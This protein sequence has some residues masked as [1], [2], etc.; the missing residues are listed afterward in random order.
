[1]I[2]LT[3]SLFGYVVALSI[4][5]GEVHAE[6]VLMYILLDPSF[7]WLHVWDLWTVG[8]IFGGVN[9]RT[10]IY[11]CMGGK[12]RRAVSIRRTMADDVLVS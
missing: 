5:L 10:K 1:M 4:F 7:R 12:Q 3:I 2:F 11:I 8:T 6:N 9:G